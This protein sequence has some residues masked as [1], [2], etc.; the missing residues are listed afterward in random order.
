MLHSDIQMRLAVASDPA[1]ETTGAAVHLRP[2][3]QFQHRSRFRPGDPPH[4]CRQPVAGPITITGVTL[5]V[6]SSSGVYDEAFA[7]GVIDIHYSPTSNKIPGAFEQGTVVVKIYAQIYSPNVDFI[8]RNSS[9][10]P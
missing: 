8:L 1:L 2:E 9:I 3:P 7:Q 4:Q 6:N 10:N 5:D